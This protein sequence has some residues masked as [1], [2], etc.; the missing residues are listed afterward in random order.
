MTIVQLFFTFAL[1]KILSS[2]MIEIPC[3]DETGTLSCPSNSL[4]DL[5]L[6]IC[7]KPCPLGLPPLTFRD[8]PYATISSTNPDAQQFSC[9]ISLKRQGH[10]F[11]KNYEWTLTPEKRYYCCPSPCITDS[12]CF[13]SAPDWTKSR[14]YACIE[15]RCQSCIEQPSLCSKFGYSCNTMTGTC[16]NCAQVPENCPYPNICYFDGTSYE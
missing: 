1:I 15:G 12:N 9:M 11:S 3:Y 10:E 5:S 16:S 8:N 14:G 4:C 13:N 6:N 7:V 2:Q